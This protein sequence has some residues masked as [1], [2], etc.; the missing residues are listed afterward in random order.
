MDEYMDAFIWI[1]MGR[2]MNLDGL[3]AV[4]LGMGIKKIVGSK[5]ILLGSKSNYY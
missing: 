1:Y 5:K 2:C 3:Q 4:A